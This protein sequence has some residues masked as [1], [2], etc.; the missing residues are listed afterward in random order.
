[1]DPGLVAGHLVQGL[2]GLGFRVEGMD[3]GLNV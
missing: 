3:L 1:M 2:K